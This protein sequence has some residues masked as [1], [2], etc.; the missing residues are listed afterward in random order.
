METIQFLGEDGIFS[1]EQPENYSA[2][3]FPIAG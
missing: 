3:Y 1:I 2:L